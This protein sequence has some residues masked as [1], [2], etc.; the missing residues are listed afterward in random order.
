MS[1]PKQDARSAPRIEN[2][3][4]V[5]VVQFDE[6][7][8]KSS[9]SMGRTMNLSRGGLELEM[10]RHIPLRSVIDISLML[11]NLGI[12]QV[13]GQV[14]HL[15]VVDDNTCRLGIAFV[16]LPDEIQAAIDEHLAKSEG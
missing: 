11:G 2:L 7:G 3:N 5:D 16:N 8:F 13:R 10:S 1:D 14:R 6:A 4:L 9:E 15:Q 12:V